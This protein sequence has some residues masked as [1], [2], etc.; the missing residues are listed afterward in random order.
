MKFRLKEIVSIEKKYYKG[1]VHDLTVDEDHSYNVNGVA[2]HN[3]MCTT[4]VMTKVGYPMAS[5]LMEIVPAVTI[6]VIADGGIRT[7]GDVAL[8][9]SLGASSVMIGSL[10]AGTKETPGAVQRANDWPTSTLYKQYRGA[11]SYEAKSSNNMKTNHIEGVST[12]VEFR[13]PVSRIVDDIL[14]GLTSSMSYVGA[15]DIFEFQAKAKH[16]RI[17][18]AGH[19]EGTP[20]GLR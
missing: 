11:A 10:F 17:S 19:I 3:S 7:P 15:Q 8:A 13:G 20:H 4:R 18:D 12:T 16:I 14:D 9:I 1:K 2:V 6:P 5:M